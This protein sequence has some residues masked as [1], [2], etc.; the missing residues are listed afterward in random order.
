[1]L[2]G[3]LEGTAPCHVPGSDGAFTDKMRHDV[4][5]QSLTDVSKE[6]D[7]P[8]LRFVGGT[9][10]YFHDGHYVSDDGTRMVRAGERYAIVRPGHTFPLGTR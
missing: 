3:R 8:S 7:T 9:A 10:P 2:A 4:G 1:M 5:S 6:L